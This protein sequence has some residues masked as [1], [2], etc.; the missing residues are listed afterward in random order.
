MGGRSAAVW[1]LI[2][3]SCFNPRAPRFGQSIGQGLGWGLPPVRA[4][5]ACGDSHGAFGWGAERGAGEGWASRAHRLFGSC[6]G[7]LGCGSW[8]GVPTAPH[9]RP[10]RSRAPFPLPFVSISGLLQP[11]LPTA[12]EPLP[13]PW[14][15]VRMYPRPPLRPRDP[16]QTLGPPCS[17]LGLRLPKMASLRPWATRDSVGHPKMGAGLA[18]RWPHPALGKADPF[19]SPPPH[20]GVA[21]AAHPPWSCHPSSRGGGTVLRAADPDVLAPVPTLR[22]GWARGSG[23]DGGRGCQPSSIPPQ[24]WYGDGGC[25]AGRTEP[26]EWGQGVWQSS[27]PCTEEAC[28]LSVPLIMQI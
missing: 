10:C 28:G 17:H 14:E 4:Q 25:R 2:R 6:R 5:G 15:Q 13:F 3:A 16:M 8:V 11:P 19:C 22:G 26:L 7:G 1:G 23:E 20:P 27:C 21:Q 24:G 12:T 9:G 18:W